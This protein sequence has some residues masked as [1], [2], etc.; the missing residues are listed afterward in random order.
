AAI[1]ETA[2]PRLIDALRAAGV[3]LKGDERALAIDAS[4]EP[5]SEADFAT[6]YLDYIANIAVV[7]G[8]EAAAAHI[9]RYGSGHTEA[10]VTQ[11]QD[12]ARLFVRLV[13]SSTVTVNAS[14]RFADG[15][16]LGLG[17]EIG[18]STTKLHA[19]GP[20]GLEEL[21]SEKFVVV[22]EGQIRV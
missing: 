22:G 21:T 1:A 20:M 17:A 19:Y 7:D 16:Q 8:V 11:D 3:T 18:I 13:D 14:T 5:A 9:E 2:L 12:R 4:L 10:I 15:G 6:E